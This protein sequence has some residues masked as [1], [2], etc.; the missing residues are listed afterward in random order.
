MTSTTIQPV[1]DPAR[2]QR[3][4]TLLELLVTLAVTVIGMAGLLALHV[5][6]LRGNDVA[7][8]SGEAVSL[9]QRQLEELRAMTLTEMTTA[10]GELP[11]DADLDTVAGRAGVTYRPRVMV[12]EMSEASSDLLR[13]RVEMA[14]TD[15]GAEAGS[16]GGVHDHMVSLE[17][18]RTRQE[19]L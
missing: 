12:V 14:W 5:T 2:R 3:G 10:L 8:R 15:D 1:R 18:V 17:V 19:D 9:A 7:S 6:T 4:F 16:N 13:M 11:I